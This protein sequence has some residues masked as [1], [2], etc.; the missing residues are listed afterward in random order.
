MVAE[1]GGRRGGAGSLASF[2]FVPFCFGGAAFFNACSGVTA[3]RQKQITELAFFFSVVEGV[4][5]MVAKVACRLGV[6]MAGGLGP[7]VP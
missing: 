1:E 6:P 7:F 5:V 3:A 4:K 2:R